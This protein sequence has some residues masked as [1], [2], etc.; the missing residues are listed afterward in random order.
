M[1]CLGM[2]SDESRGVD[3]D[4]AIIRRRYTRYS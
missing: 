2:L 4:D 1:C 3:D